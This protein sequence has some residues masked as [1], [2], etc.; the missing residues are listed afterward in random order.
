METTRLQHRE[1][2]Y[3]LNVELARARLMKVVQ[4][5]EDWNLFDFPRMDKLQQQFQEAQDLFVEALTRQQTEPAAAAGYADQALEIAMDMSEQLAMF[6]SDLL[7]NRRR[8]NGPYVRHMFGCRI[9]PTI[10]NEKYRETALNS[11]DYAILPIPWRLLQPTEQE[12]NTTAI[13]EWVEVHL[14]KRLRHD[15]RPVPGVHP[16]GGVPLSQGRVGLER[17]GGAGL[18][19]PLPHEL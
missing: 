8:L 10:Q 1:E 7:L 3:I 17:G 9:D 5:R 6:H 18:Q 15:A 12:F 2:P 4:K 16:E 19:H 13:D 11:F 14:G